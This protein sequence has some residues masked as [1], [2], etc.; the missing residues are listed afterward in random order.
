M[1]DDASTDIRQQAVATAR[2]ASI[3]TIKGPTGDRWRRAVKQ[4][5]LPARTPL[6]DNATL[7][8]AVR[9]DAAELLALMTPVVKAF[10]TDNGWETTTLCQQV[11]GGHGYIKDYGIEQFVRNARIAQLYEGANG[12][13]AMD[14]VQ[15]KLTAHG[16]R[17]QRAAHAGFVLDDHGHAQRLA[18]AFREGAHDTV[19]AATGG[20]GRDQLD[21]A[22]GE[23][24]LC[25][26]VRR[27]ER[28]SGHGGS[29]RQDLAAVEVGGAAGRVAHAVSPVAMK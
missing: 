7:D 3:E 14:L 19:A 4:L 25:E 24:V 18:G 17:A 10:L 5:G 11:L 29:G 12:V 13:Q 6:P 2:A 27:Q 28:R 15:R 8:A 16:G 21:G 26:R 23:L 9:E 1:I 22:V 20:P